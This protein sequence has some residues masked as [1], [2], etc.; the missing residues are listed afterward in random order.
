M[1]KTSLMAVALATVV[2]CYGGAVWAATG[3]A[4]R[5]ERQGPS[6]SQPPYILG[7]DHGVAT[8]SVLTA[9]DVVDG[10]PMVGLMD[11]LGAYDN[12]DGTFTLLSNHE[13]G[14]TAG[15]PR[16]HGSTGSFVARW[17]IDKRSLEVLHGEDLIQR[18]LEWDG[19]QWAETTT[20]FNRFCSANLPERVAFADRRSHTGT[21]N[22]LFMNGEEAGSEGRAVAHVA[23]GP[24]AG[25]SYPL[26]WLGHAS[27]ENIVAQPERGRATVVAGLDDSGGGQV[28]FYR[29]L[30]Q[31]HGNDVER[32]GL[33]HGSLYGL[34]I[35]GVSSENDSTSLPDSGAPFSLVEIPGAASMTGAELEAASAALDVTALARPE[36]G[37]WD[38]SDR[39]GFYFA[40]TAGFTS[41]SRLW[42]LD[43]D[44]PKNVLAG[45]TARVVTQSP[46]Y[47]ASA[48]SAAQTGPRMMD[49]VTVSPR[50][51]VLVQEDPGGQDYVAGV[52]EVDPRTGT[53]TRIA[54]HDPALFATGSPGL[55]TNDE[56]SSGIIPVPFLGR[57]VFLLDSQAHDAYGDPEIVEGGQLV[58]LRLPHRRHH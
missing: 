39:H 38:P 42:H 10:Y 21:W 16:A 56:E 9:G 48:T 45:G 17:T 1:R 36:D 8:A 18:V 11:G 27:W 31:R 47:D 30:K 3:D 29:G 34:K 4:D 40:T 24:D 14:A 43:F 54:G 6:S 52:F 28:Y 53:A 15:V 19:A 7:A 26:P 50:G 22:R 13:L 58:L 57:D 55:L 41:I 51:R 33:T 44:N 2:G 25:S 12:H 35:D 37:S 5:M 49:N 20:A 23:T 46:A 32:A